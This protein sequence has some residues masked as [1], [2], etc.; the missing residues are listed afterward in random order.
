MM[1]QRIDI[2]NKKSKFVFRY[3]D[4]WLTKILGGCM[5]KSISLYLRLYVY[6]TLLVCA[7]GYYISSSVLLGNFTSVQFG[8]ISVITLTLIILIPEKVLSKYDLG[9]EALIIGVLAATTCLFATLYTV[10]SISNDVS[11]NIKLVLSISGFLFL[12]S[13]AIVC[14]SEEKVHKNVSLLSALC[15][16]GFSLAIF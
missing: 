9:I 7:T 15:Y 10:L 4:S 5:F 8:V 16:L 11:N 6:T 14:N 2:R 13:V 1:A 3:L 12:L